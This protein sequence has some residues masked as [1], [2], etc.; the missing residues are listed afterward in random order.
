MVSVLSRP[1]QHVVAVEPGEDHLAAQAVVVAD[2]VAGD[3]EAEQAVE[4]DR[5][6]DE[7]AEVDALLVEG[8]RLA[9]RGEVAPELLE[10]VH[11]VG[12]ALLDH[13]RVERQVA[14]AVRAV[15]DEVP[16]DEGLLR[17]LLVVEQQ[18]DVRRQAEAQGVA[19]GPGDEPEAGRLAIAEDAAPVEVDGLAGGDGL[20]EEDR[21][22]R[23]VALGEADELD[24]HER[25]VVVGA[26]LLGQPV[27]PEGARHDGLEVAVRVAVLR[28]HREHREVLDAVDALAGR[29][30]TGRASRRSRGRRSRRRP[31]T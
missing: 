8:Q 29:G 12:H 18:V 25:G 17:E 7:A 13:E 15:V 5:V 2:P 23:V 28:V 4:H 19:G 14:T 20:G 1:A 21:R 31:T 11:P 27:R 30:G 24:R 22:V 16:Q 6:P 9:E 3:G 26:L 10:R